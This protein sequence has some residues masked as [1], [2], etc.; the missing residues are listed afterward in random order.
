MRDSTQESLI[1]ADQWRNTLVEDPS[2]TPTTGIYVKN[3]WFRGHRKNRAG[4][5]SAGAGNESPAT[6]LARLRE[7]LALLWEVA[8]SGTRRRLLLVVALIG[9]ASLMTALTPVA[10][11]LAVDSFAAPSQEQLSLSPAF[12]IVLYVAGQYFWR[13]FSELRFVPHG[14]VQGRIY[15]NIGL[16]M[17]EHV[18]RLPMRYHLER[19]TGAIGQV[20]EQG[21]D[22]CEQLLHNTVYII[23]PVMLE[24]MAVGIVLV[25][26]GYP[27]YLAILAVA[28]VAYVIVFERGATGIQRPSREMSAARIDAHASMTDNLLNAEAIKYYDAESTVAQRY[29]KSLARV[30][31]SWQQFA[32]QRAKNGLLIATVFSLSLGGSLIYAAHDVSRGVMTIGDFVLVNAYIMRFVSP[33][34]LL[35]ASVR[36][37][38]RALVNLQAFFNIL[39]EQRETDL[40]GARPSVDTRGGALTFENVSFSY[41]RE[42]AVLANV[43]F[44]IPA[45]QTLAVVGVSGSGKS[46]LVRLL[47]RLYEPDA[48]GIILDGVPITELSL[49]ALRRAIAV[50]PQDTVLFHESIASNIAFGKCGATQA[51]IEE[52]ARIANLHEFIKRQP[53]GY[54]TVVGERGLKL[55]GGERQRVA[56]ARAALKQP[57]IFVFDEATSSLDSTTEGEI[58]RNFTEVAS[59]ST[60]LVIA[61]RLSTIVHADEIVV[62][63]QGIIAERGTHANLL[64]KNG[65]YA[66]LWRAQAGGA[67]STAR[68]IAH[69]NLDATSRVE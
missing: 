10:L 61:H 8:D 51:E 3:S 63:D 36:E 55:S 39:R 45:G 32:A 48:G 13:C 5:A 4:V 53:D 58:L 23:L 62:L 14:Q 26:F 69:S 17:F 52:A 46:S 49:S 30:E 34:E 44:H 56:I 43:S 67:G 27:I 9:G 11:K 66:A 7:G 18:L 54:Q 47:F 20:V 2:S 33:L 40:P 68:L 50:V 29:D 16:L 24:F 41:R 28:A 19:R 65:R 42:I 37:T 64:Q 59:A 31:V 12:L 25:H 22:A 15:R 60:T 6:G 57:R 35:G 21:I 38:S 1:S